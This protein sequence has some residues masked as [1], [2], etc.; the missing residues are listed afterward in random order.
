MNLILFDRSRREVDEKCPRARYWNYEWQRTGLERRSINQHLSYGIAVHDALAIIMEEVKETDALP[1]EALVTAAIESALFNYRQTVAKRGLDLQQTSIIEEDP[2]TG[3]F[4]EVKADTQ[5]IVDQYSDMLEAHVRGWVMV[6]LPAILQDFRVV[7]VE[8]EKRLLIPITFTA[9][10]EERVDQE[11]ALGFMARLDN[12]LERRVDHALVVLNF[13]TASECK[14][15]WLEQWQT[16]QQTISEMLPIEHEYGKPCAGV[17]IEGLVKGKQNTEWPR[18]SH[19]WYHNSPLIFAWKKEGDG[20]AETEWASRF[21]FI[22]QDGSRRRLGKGWVRVRAYDYPGGIHGWLNY[23]RDR[24]PELLRSQFVAPPLVSRQ[25][26]EVQE[27]LE[28]V[29]WREYEIWD[30]AV[31]GPAPINPLT[32]VRYF[33]KET[34]NANCLFPGK[35]QFYDICWGSAKDD[36][37]GSGLY[38]IR[39]PHHPEPQDE[40]E[41]AV[42]SEQ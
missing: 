33:R 12:L 20:F 13:K 1:S 30:S 32:L 11:N 8:V 31:Q 22:D 17:L 28:Q 40:F 16:D 38:Q 23:L 2:Y 7:D 29:K 27:W 6:R 36:P 10:E 5:W 41:K 21:E 14:S 37:L 25:D 15:Y 3:G 4:V 9:G 26:S 39:T 35:C 18:N 19:H 34:H 42:A 24:D